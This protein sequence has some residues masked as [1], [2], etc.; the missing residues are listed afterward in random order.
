[1]R[2]VSRGSGLGA[3]PDEIRSIGIFD[4][5][6]RHFA[7][8]TEPA[9]RSRRI[10]IEEPGI[11]GPEVLP[12]RAALNQ[13]ERASLVSKRGGPLRRHVLLQAPEQKPVQR[14]Q[15]HPPSQQASPEARARQILGGHRDSRLI[16]SA[17]AYRARRVCLTTCA[18]A[19]AANSLS[20]TIRYPRR[21][22]SGSTS[23][24]IRTVRRPRLPPSCST[25]IAPG[26]AFRRM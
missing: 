8:V 12:I 26:L 22:N 18:S 14:G 3:A 9:Q 21:R 2:M 4:V 20:E 5:F 25:T 1:M 7:E 13:P 6:D 11:H 19:A 24:R 15:G 17:L 16:I 10:E 23:A